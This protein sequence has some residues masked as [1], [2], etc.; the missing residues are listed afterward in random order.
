MGDLN[1]LMED[2]CIGRCDICYAEYDHKKQVGR[3]I[4]EVCRDLVCQHAARIIRPWLN[5][6]FMGIKE[7]DETDCM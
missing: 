7:E 3:D 2:D 1:D 6:D 4:C 5:P